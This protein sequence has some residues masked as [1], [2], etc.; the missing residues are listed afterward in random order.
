MGRIARVVAIG[1]P[2]HVTQIGNN[3]QQIFFDDADRE[4]YLRLLQEQFQ[5]WGIRLLG[6]CLMS[7]HTH[8]VAV[9]ERPLSFARGLG[10][11]HLCY[12]QYFN[13]RHQHC[14]RLWR[15][16][17]FSCPLDLRHLRT[18]LRYVDLNP[19]RAHMVAA[20]GEYR[21][22][23]AA[24]HI[25]QCDPRGLLDMAFWRA[26]NPCRDWREVLA[27]G[28][29]EELWAALREATNTGRPMG[30]EGFVKELGAKLSRNLERAKP[31]RPVKKEPAEAVLRS[32]ALF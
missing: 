3:K 13:L 17:F 19:V 10:Q 32:G 23:S 20:A 18:A 21:W 12:T 22:S 25:D 5:H 24:A 15:N 8:L 27:G 4:M 1:V 7:N 2:H 26:F 31:G 14:G 9:P 29:D 28:D 16:R 11:T 6:Y 30:D